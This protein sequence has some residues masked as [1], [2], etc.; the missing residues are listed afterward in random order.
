MTTINGHLFI[1]T[2]VCLVPSKF[3]RS[4]IYSN[5]I[6]IQSPQSHRICMKRGRL[7]AYSRFWEGRQIWQQI[8]DLG[9]TETNGFQKW[10]PNMV[11]DGTPYEILWIWFNIYI[12]GW[13]RG[14][15]FCRKPTHGIWPAKDGMSQTRQDTMHPYIIRTSIRK[16]VHPSIHSSIRTDITSIDLDNQFKSLVVCYKS[17]IFLSSQRHL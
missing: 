10:I 17:N 15:I 6:S 4:S 1:E 9:R 3:L 8:L 11:Y 12:Y 13:F 7:Q 5:T 2:S 16:Y 14:T